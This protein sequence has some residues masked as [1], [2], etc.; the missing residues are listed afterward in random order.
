MCQ[1]KKQPQQKTKNPHKNDAGF[2]PLH[3][4]E[5]L[6]GSQIFIQSLIAEGVTDIFGYPGGSVI[7]LYE[8]LYHTKQIKHYLVRH[9]QAAIHAAEGY[10]RVSGKAEIGRAHV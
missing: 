5:I 9:E 3:E 1:L 2:Q 7:G 6:T 10:A 8:E 4:G